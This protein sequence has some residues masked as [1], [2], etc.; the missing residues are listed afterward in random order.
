MY[1]HQGAGWT[2]RAFETS[3]AR[4]CHRIFRD[5]V[6]HFPW[7]GDIAN[8]LPALKRA[9]DLDAAYVAHEPQAGV[10]GFITM[11]PATRYVDHLFVTGDWRLCGVG[12]GLIAVAREQAGGPLT[13]DVDTQNTT[14][15][16]AYEALGWQM[17]ADAPPARRRQQLR[18][19]SP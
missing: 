3:D 10:I 8:Y 13:L 14:A 18:L 16:K 1:K 12:R 15:R 4:V 7:R 2:I 5:C 17:M 9:L 19:I 6:A 11:Q